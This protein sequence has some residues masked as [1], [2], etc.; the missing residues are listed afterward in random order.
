MLTTFFKNK[1]N[2]LPFI[3]VTMASDGEDYGEESSFALVGRYIHK[4]FELDE[5][6]KH[7]GLIAEFNPIENTYL[8]SAEII[9]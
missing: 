1:T 4:R 3:S 2:Y 5:K 7:I 9:I 8:V 6:K